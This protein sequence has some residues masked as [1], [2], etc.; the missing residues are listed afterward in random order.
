MHYP[1]ISY[2][3]K[4]VHPIAETATETFFPTHTKTNKN[5]EISVTI[6]R[7]RHIKIDPIIVKF[8]S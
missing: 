2:Q 8:S 1:M 6:L 5:I 4:E 3:T 7:L